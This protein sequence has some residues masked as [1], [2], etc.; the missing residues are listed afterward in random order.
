MGSRT[1]PALAFVAAT[2]LVGLFMTASPAAAE[3]PGSARPGVVSGSSRGKAAIE[4]A[5]RRNRYLFLF[6]W[7]END[8][9]SLAMYG[10]FRAAMSN[11]G[12]WADS[13]GIQIADAAEKELVDKFDLGRAPMPLVL[14][15]APNGAVTKG[16]PVTFNEQQLRQAFVSPCT[17]KCLRAIQQRKLVVLCVQNQAT[18]LN[19][20]ALKGVQDFKA[21]PRFGQAT[22]VVFLNPADTA[23]AKFLQGFQ[24]DPRTPTAVT[25]LLVPPGG[26]IGK[27]EGAVTK[28]ALLAKLTASQSNPCAGGQC[29]P[30]GCGPKK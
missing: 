24:V 8:E 19:R 10:V 22:E 13:A 12:Q 11:L 29:G 4:E 26:T 27:F 2:A 5:A 14:A 28:E 20:V 7:K 21:D 9:H 15:L 1:E 30:N 25:L 23:E 18:Q 17:A 16:F 6:F 3:R